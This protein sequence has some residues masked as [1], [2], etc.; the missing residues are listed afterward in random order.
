M[1]CVRVEGKNYAEAEDR[2]SLLATRMN[3][4]KH[5]FEVYAD[6][7]LSDDDDNEGQRVYYL[8]NENVPAE[9]T[10]EEHEE[11]LLLGGHGVGDE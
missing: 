4:E 2:A 1:I 5:S 6:V 3:S 8:H 9:L 7:V 10:D 11:H